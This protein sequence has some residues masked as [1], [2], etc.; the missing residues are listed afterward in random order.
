[1]KLT[2]K[3]LREFA[4]FNSHDFTSARGVQNQNYP[5]D[6]PVPQC[7]VYRGHRIV[8]RI[9][10]SPAQQ[11]R[12]Y[13]SACWQV[14]QGSIPTDPNGHWRDHGYITFSVYAR[15]EKQPRFEEALAW[16]SDYFGVTEWKKDPFGDWIPAD[17]HAART[18]QLTDWIKE[19]S[20]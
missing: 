13:K 12:G 10:Y 5:L 18:K 7:P 3:L 16:A 19:M 2:P 20:A 6:R 4:F 9:S 17:F 1:M 11:G 14:V 8:P 15:D